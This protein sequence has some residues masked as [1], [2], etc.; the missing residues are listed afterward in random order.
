LAGIT[1]NFKE[2]EGTFC[3]VYRWADEGTVQF[4]T[5]INGYVSILVLNLKAITLTG[6]GGL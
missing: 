3:H 5:T 4:V 1:N 2:S 6:R